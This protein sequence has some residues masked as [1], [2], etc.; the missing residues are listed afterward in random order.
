MAT[1]RGEGSGEG[2]AAIAKR[3]EQAVIRLGDVQVLQT[4]GL[5][6]TQIQELQMVYAKGMLDVNK[7]AQELKVDVGALEATLR[8]M[9]EQTRRVAESGDSVTISHAQASTLGRTEIMM[10]NTQ[11]AASGKL[12]RSQTGEQD[13][14]LIYLV[15]G[16]IVVIFAAFAL[17]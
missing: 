13:K 17:R 6:E 14:T 12:S 4:A 3:D 1:E 11:R 5:S 16:A 10:G 7:K 8:T 15:I 2:T 9:A